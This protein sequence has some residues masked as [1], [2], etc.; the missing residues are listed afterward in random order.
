MLCC[1][2]VNDMRK[3]L[4]L[5]CFWHQIHWNLEKMTA[6][7]LLLRKE[8]MW[9][10]SSGILMP[11]LAKWLHDSWI[12]VHFWIASCRTMDLFSSAWSILLWWWFCWIVVAIQ[13]CFE[14]EHE[15]FHPWEPI[16][17]AF[18]Q[19]FVHHD[20]SDQQCTPGLDFGLLIYNP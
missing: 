2:K 18:L 17:S 9:F 10:S 14:L 11:D 8:S 19:I 1:S 3:P 6:L 20:P 15:W 12:L 5:H 4:M 7:G 13:W 16:Q